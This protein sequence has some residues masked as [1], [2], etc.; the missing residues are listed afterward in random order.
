MSSL[1]PRQIYSLN[2]NWVENYAGDK[3]RFREKHY[4]EEEDGEEEEVEKGQ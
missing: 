2:V 4:D 3:G 1:G